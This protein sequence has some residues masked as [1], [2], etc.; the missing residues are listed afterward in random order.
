MFEPIGYDITAVGSGD[1]VLRLV[2]DERFAVVLLEVGMRGPEGGLTTE[3]L[4]QPA[5]HR[6]TPVVLLTARQDDRRHATLGTLSGAVGYIFEPYEPNVIR[7][8][9]AAF[10]AL[11]DEP[12]ELGRR[13][14]DVV[15]RRSDDDGERASVRA[16]EAAARAEAERARAAAEEANRIKSEFLATMSHEFR[17]PLNAIIGYAQLL[18]MGVLGPATAAQHAHL[19]R[20]QSSARHLL[21]IVNDVLDVAKT[22]AARMETR[23]DLLMSGAAVAAA[24]TLVQPQA[25]AA[26]VRLIDLRAESPG[27]AYIGDEHRVRQVLVNLI[28]NAIKFTPAGGQTTVECTSVD[29]PEP[30]VWH[31]IGDVERPDAPRAWACITVTDTGPGLSPAVMRRLFDAFAQG[32]G[33]LTREKGGAGLGLAISRRLARLMGGDLTARNVNGPGGATGATFTLWLPAPE[34]ADRVKALTRPSNVFVRASPPLGTAAI[35]ASSG[36]SLTPD[37]YAVLHALSGRLAVNAEAVA[38]HYVAA[39]HADERFPNARELSTVQLRDHVTPFVGLL[40]SQLM[41]I[42]E[43]HGQ[44]AELLEDGGNVQRV[45]AEL[46]GAQRFRIGWG[47][48]DMERETSVML[49]EI[50]RVIR[51]TANLNAQTAGELTSNPHALELATEYAVSVAQHVLQRALRISIRAHR[52]A[53]SAAT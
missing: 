13:F 5:Q 45:M 41:I 14:A 33:A 43:T 3:A 23:H 30:G 26:G 53:K 47:E 7:S 51:A 17:T 25:T 52:F 32:D 2:H 44:A 40:A 15:A 29:E 6:R 20:L 37:A 34:P 11:T 49:T 46:H 10:A 16:A 48:I 1:D 24:I 28:A 42:G 9:V 38:E 22:D 12:Q 27:V 18:D 36:P 35:A 21:Q 4:R 19:D 39:L 31:G 50:T 8:K